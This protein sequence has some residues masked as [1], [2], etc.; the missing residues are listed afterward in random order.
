MSTV[1]PLSLSRPAPAHPP[2]AYDDGRTQLLLCLHGLLPI[3]F[4]QA[5]YNIPL[6]IW[7]PRDYPK[8][9]P[10][11]YVLATPDMLIRSSQYIELSGRCNIEYIQNWQRKS[12]VRDH[13]ILR[14]LDPTLIR[15][16]SRVAASS[17]SWK[18]CRSTSPKSLPSTRNPG[19]LQPLIPLFL[20]YRPTVIPQNPHPRS[21]V[22]NTSTDRRQTHLFRPP[23]HHRN[24]SRY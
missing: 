17:V 6:A 15:T 3:T 5:A 16:D 24:R 2:L 11:P 1:Q 8:D 4:R 22:H 7:L 21:P 10:I 9:H 23:H 13:L 18:P 12:E 19:I 20:R 14:S